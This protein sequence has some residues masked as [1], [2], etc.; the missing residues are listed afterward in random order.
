M[1][2]YM[3][4]SQLYIYIHIYIWDIPIY[5]WYNNP[6]TGMHHHA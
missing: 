4:Y 5:I 1:D 3:G 6:L 2:I